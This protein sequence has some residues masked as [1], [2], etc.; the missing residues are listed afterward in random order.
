MHFAFTEEQQ[1]LRAAVRDL[2]AKECPPSAV[3][4][5]WS[6]ETGRVPGLWKHLAESGVL[7][8]CVPPEHEGL[9]LTE[10]EMTPIM[11]ELG[12]ACTPD[13][14]LETS[15]VALPLLVELGRKEL[16]KAAT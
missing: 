13:P 3:R 10:L 15:A 9:G 5:A 14:V 1:Q 2:L 6:S 12:R 4:G 11:E 7:G 16:L 8:L